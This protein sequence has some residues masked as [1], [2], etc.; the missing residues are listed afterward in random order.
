MTSAPNE[1]HAVRLRGW[2][3][4]LA[5]VVAGV[6]ALFATPSLCRE[7]AAPSEAASPA[8]APEA[9]ASASPGRPAAAPEP[10]A[11]SPVTV[12]ALRKEATEVAARLRRDYPL[13]I[14]PIALTGTVHH[15]LGNSEAAVTCWQEC[16]RRDPGR[17]DAYSGMAM[18]A[19][20]KEQ[21]QKAETL[22][23]SAVERSPRVGGLRNG[24]ARALLSQGKTEEAVEVLKQEVAMAP[25]ASFSHVLLGQAYLQLKAY[26]KAKQHYQTA[27]SLRP[28]DWNAH[29]GL[30][31]VCDRLGQ[32]DEAHKHR[33]TVK[34]LKAKGLPVSTGRPPAADDLASLRDGVARVHTAAGRFCHKRGNVDQAERHWRRA[35]EIDPTNAACRVHLAALLKVDP[36]TTPEARRLYTALQTIEPA[37]PMH[38]LNA[39][40]IDVWAG[41]FDDAER[42]FLHV[43][44]L[45]PKRSLGCA[46]LAQLY[47]RANRKLPEAKALAEEAVKLE[48]AASNYAI[49][50]EACDKNGDLP[51]ACAAMNRAL[52]LEPRNV[53]YRRILESLKR[54]VK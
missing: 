18:I 31:T 45:A 46:G 21:Y 54:R 2:R 40:I 20:Q 6:L 7:A 50:S 53:R 32:T 44:Q 14:D 19:F 3:F 5:V 27:V 29:D 12:E 11:G 35:A 24:L 17:A 26:Q 25:R 47:L 34:S 22:W 33:E 4:L 10:S 38:W 16:V 23:R 41:R 39:A 30:A 15:L 8:V 13:D 52:E 1:S 43:R 37:N 48:P 42:G 51:G 28:D 49:L 36:A 9:P